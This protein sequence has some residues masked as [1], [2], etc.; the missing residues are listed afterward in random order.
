MTVSNPFK[1]I[2]EGCGT[3]F[4]RRFRKGGKLYVSNVRWNALRFCSRKCGLAYRGSQIHAD[5]VARDSNGRICACC[6]ERKPLTEFIQKKR[7]NGGTCPHAYCKLCLPKVNRE[8][9]L[10]RQFNIS[11]AEY[12]RIL[13]HQ[14]GGCAICGRPPREDGNRL[15]IDHDHKTGLVRGLLCRTCN[16]LLALAYDDTKRLSRAIAYLDVPPATTVLGED[17]FTAPGRVGTKR[18]SKLLSKQQFYATH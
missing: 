12:E 13:Y 7:K 4:Y 14:N 16:K 18:R 5:R 11:V 2:C 15:A 3:E 8:R 10:K 6:H 1:K 9:R 17:R